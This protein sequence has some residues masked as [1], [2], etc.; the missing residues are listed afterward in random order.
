MPYA[1]VRNHFM[2]LREQLHANVRGFADMTVDEVAALTGSAR[3]R[4]CA[5]Q[6]ARFR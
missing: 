5:G 6:A 1:E 3:E 4:G 2:R